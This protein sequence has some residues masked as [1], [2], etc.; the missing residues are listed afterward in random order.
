MSR[1]KPNA[2]GWLGYERSSNIANLTFI[3]DPL[4]TLKSAEM[5]NNS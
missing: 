5:M 3:D 1:K 2:L 4:S